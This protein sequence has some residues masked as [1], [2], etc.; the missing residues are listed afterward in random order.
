MWK[1][2]C[3]TLMRPRFSK[4][5]N[6]EFIVSV[7]ESMKLVFQK[8]VQTRKLRNL[9]FQGGPKTVMFYTET[10]GGFSAGAQIVDQALIKDIDFEIWC[11]STVD[12][13]Y[14]GPI[15]IHYEIEENHES[16][17]WLSFWKQFQEEASKK[18][19]VLSTSAPEITN[20]MTPISNAE[21]IRILK[22]QQLDAIV[23]RD[24]RIQ[25][26]EELKS[27]NHKVPPPGTLVFR[28]DDE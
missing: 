22:Q 28:L 1:P 6:N 24:K 10:L 14:T 19:V 25:E 4:T 5:E 16:P 23:A 7:Y 13:P 20:V 9:T 11:I 12:Q 3:I 15:Y 26:E 21:M 2:E 27:K 8:E 17:S 18:R